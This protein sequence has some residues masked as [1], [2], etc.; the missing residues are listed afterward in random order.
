MPFFAR[1]GLCGSMRFLVCMGAAREACEGR[2]LSRE[3]SKGSMSSRTVW[4]FLCLALVCSS[5]MA[6][7]GLGAGGIVWIDNYAEA[8]AETRATGKPLFLTF[9]CVP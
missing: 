6:G 2:R 5:A 3:D 4:M 7:R 8:I 1:G 9:R